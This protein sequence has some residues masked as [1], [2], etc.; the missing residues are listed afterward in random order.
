M[1]R[2][3]KATQRN[4]TQKKKKKKSAQKK[5]FWLHELKKNLFLFGG[6][7]EGRTDLNSPK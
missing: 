4:A 1:V 6:R 3:I 2:N 5:I 7:G